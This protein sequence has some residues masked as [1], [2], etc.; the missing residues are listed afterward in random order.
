MHSRP[1]PL[2]N[3][4]GSLLVVPLQ[5]ANQ[6]RVNFRARRP[7]SGMLRPTSLDDTSQRIRAVA[8]NR[9]SGTLIDN[10]SRDAVL[11]FLGK[12]SLAG[13]DLPQDERERVNCEGKARTGKI[14]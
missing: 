14:K 11:L 6:V 2:Q 10:Q 1:V 7:V 8:G 13:D 12:G 5:R 4:L 9:R 3:A